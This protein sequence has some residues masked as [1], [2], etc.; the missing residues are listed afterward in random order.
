[1][2]LFAWRPPHRL[3]ILADTVAAVL[4]ALA[5]SGN[6]PGL[7]VSAA[8]ALACWLLVVPVAVRRIWPVAAYCGALLISVLVLALQ[9]NW[10]MTMVVVAA[11]VY[12]VATTQPVRR[13]AVALI[14]GLLVAGA[15]LLVSALGV[16]RRA[17]GWP[18]P[19][20][21]V[22]MAWLVVGASWS[23]G[24]AART[25]REFAAREVKRRAEQAA[26]DERLRIA[27]E[28]HDVV[29]H[30]MSMITVKAGVAAKVFGKHPEEGLKALR[31]IEEIGRGSLV[32][33]RHF[34]GALR[35]PG[36]APESTPLPSLADL[37]SLTRRAAEA[38]VEVDLSVSGT[39]PDSM[40][41]AVYRIVQEAITN[42]IRHAAPARCR[43]GV[44]AADGSLRISVVDDGP[45][46]RVLPGRAG[47]HGLAGMRERAMMYGGTFEAGPLPTGGFGVY[48]SWK[49]P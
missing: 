32:E 33:M 19:V 7:T 39:V 48:A 41:L 3:L 29:A 45:G 47:G 12:T 28:L 2:N 35:S 26:V 37:P 10:L 31:A 40:G 34:L 15:A 17:D 43:V 6:P 25:R 16:P 42:V 30:S 27:R 8:S 24:T 13:S 18:D 20:F 5:S 1:M 14:P 36:S 4:F 9:T 23:L 21:V 44:S 11:T 46:Q 49:L 38:G 22:V